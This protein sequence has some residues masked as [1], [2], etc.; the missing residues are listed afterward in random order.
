MIFIYTEENNKREDRSAY[1][2]EENMKNT[3]F[4]V[5]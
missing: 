1:K 3:I 4:F 5:K 2:N